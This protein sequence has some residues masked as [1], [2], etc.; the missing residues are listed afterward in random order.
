MKT[1][2][3]LQ[4]VGK[5]LHMAW[6][7]VLICTSVTIAQ[8]DSKYM[9]IRR[10]V[11]FGYELALSRQQGILQ[12]NIPQLQQL[13]VGDNGATLGVKL[14]N[15]KGALRAHMGTYYS[16]ASTP[17]S[18]NLLEAGVTGNIY[19]LRL[20]N[21]EQVQYH[22]FEPYALVSVMYQRAQFFGT[23]LHGDNNN[24]SVCNEPKLGSLGWV[25][26]GTGLGVEYQLENNK[27][28]F[29]HL[30]AE[31][32]YGVPFMS[33]SSNTDFA[34]TT[35]KTPLTFALGICFGKFR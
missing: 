15:S 11:Y 16:C 10:P 9:E 20:G 35:M 2:I 22:S 32:K 25:N 30:F 23:Y 33:R 14:A 5:K 4:E 8:D 24:R 19:L 7:A 31:A 29:I 28:E 13:R 27:L 21:K 26:A 12:S 6:M 17:Y 34:Q 18:I 3:Q 1:G